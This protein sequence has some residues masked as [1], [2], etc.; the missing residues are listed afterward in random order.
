MTKLVGFFI[1]SKNLTEMVAFY[2][3]LLNAEIENDGDVHFVI[4]LPDGNGGFVIWDDGNVPDSVN[5]KV[6]L[7]FTVDDVD[8]EY[9]KLLKMN[10]PIIEPPIDNPWGGRHMVFCD[11]DGNRV[12]FV[13]P[14]HK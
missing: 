11:P 7:W 1:K 12:W 9:E 14:I 6:V 3:G 8:G 2:K 4:N 5:E 13:T 10:A